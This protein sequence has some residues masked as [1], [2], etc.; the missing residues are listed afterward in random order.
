[1]PCRAGSKTANTAG[2]E[3]L[4]RCPDP[5]VPF[6]DRRGGRQSEA[7]RVHAR[8]MELFVPGR[9][10]LFGEHSD[11]AGAHRASHPGLHPGRCL[12]AGTRQGLRAEA[13]ALDEPVFALSLPDGRSLRAPHEDLPAVARGE[14]FFRHAAGTAL[15]VLE[16]HGVAAGLELRITEAD[17]PV[18]KGLSSSAAACVLVARAF[19][20]VHGLGLSVEDEMEL[21]YHGERRTGSECG[22]MDQVC[23][24]GPVTTWLG[25]DGEEVTREPVEVGAPM[26]LLVVDL[27]ASK[28]TR[29]ILADLQACFPD[30]P[31]AL[32]AGVREALGLRNARLSERAR[33]LLEAGDAPALGELMT[34]AQALFDQ[35][36]VPASAA[37]DAPRQRA[38]LGSPEARELA[39][40]GKGVGSQGE[41][42]VQL[43][44]RGP[45]EAAE[46][47]SRLEER[48]GVA[49]LGL[50]LGESRP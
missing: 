5:A 23:A 32:A 29:R 1:M 10:C 31:G 8:V 19:G 48:F 35:L 41:G 28:D 25:F 49:T 17:L 43:L 33:A 3:S 4:R 34:E 18:A 39:W 24:L 21:A 9:L 40:G 13:A 12:V 30:A 47:A 36:V 38:V 16:R 37:L 46:L 42:S 44:A 22:R 15:E 26:H 2:V 14:D 11:W 50:V 20:R 6:P 7:L 27:A 45:E